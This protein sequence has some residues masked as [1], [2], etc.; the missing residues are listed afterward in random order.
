MIAFHENSGTGSGD[1]ISLGQIERATTDFA[2]V[3]TNLKDV[4]T[5]MEQELDKIRVKYL[6]RIRQHVALCADKQAALSKLIELAPGLFEKPRT[7]TFMGIK[8]GLR[9]GSGG[10]DWEDDAKVVALI[11]KNFKKDQA[12]LLIKTTEKPI[13]KALQDLDV[14]ELKKIGCTV[15]ST[16]D[17][18]VIKPVDGEVDKLVN[19]LLKDATE[20]AAVQS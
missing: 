1:P 16:G 4:V 6:K 3:R 18:V 20:E 2:A 15:E 8:V 9:K 10:I 17:V 13:A 5:D 19:A 14:S 11:R 7:H 12:D